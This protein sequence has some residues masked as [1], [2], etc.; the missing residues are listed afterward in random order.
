MTAIKSVLARGAGD[1]VS[2]ARLYSLIKV[3]IIEIMRPLRGGIVQDDGA[4][5]RL[6]VPGDRTPKT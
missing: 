5:C 6:A 3:R 2:H 1:N 4:C